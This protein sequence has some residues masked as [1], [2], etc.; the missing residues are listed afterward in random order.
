MYADRCDLMGS[1]LVHRM[2][3]R[4]R[5][6]GR[7]NYRMVG[8]NELN[9][10][11][12][13]LGNDALGN[14]QRRQNFLRRL[15]ACAR[16]QSGIVPRLLRRKRCKCINGFIDFLNSC[17]LGFLPNFATVSSARDSHSEYSGTPACFSCC[18]SFWKRFSFQL[19]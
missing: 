8:D 11:C 4:Q 1:Q 17:H 7:K 2:L 18:A 14:I 15:C 16:Q 12:G 3:H 10:L 6:E 9:T 13:R 5:L 19:A